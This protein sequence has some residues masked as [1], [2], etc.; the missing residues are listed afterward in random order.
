MINPLRV[1][2]SLRQ[3]DRRAKIA[4]PDGSL[5]AF[6]DFEYFHYALGDFLTISTEIACHAIDNACSGIDCFIAIDPGRPAAPAQGFINAENYTFHLEN[7]APA[8]LC[9]PM[10]RSVHFLRDRGRTAGFYRQAAKRLRRPIWPNYKS[11]I[12][13]RITY[14]LGHGAIND[15]FRRRGYV[16]Q[17]EA[18]KGYE[19]WAATYIAKNIPNRFLVAVHPRQSRLSQAPATTYRDAAL[20][21]W[22]TLFRHCASERPD[23]HFLLMGG[24]SEWHRDLY[25]LPNI[26]IPRALGLNLAH[27]LALMQRSD[28]FLGSSSGFATMATFSDIPYQ[29]SNVEHMFAPFAGIEIGENYPFAGENQNLHWQPENADTLLQFLDLVYAEG[30]D[31]HRNDGRQPAGQT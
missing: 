12:S 8:I 2:Q 16:P 29:I 14:P 18:P 28:L 7:L 15:F 1:I 31:R 3:F 20:E 21:E 11:Q 24:F 17:L 19:A 25:V 27:E 9:T 22:K 13:K 10:L 30:Q 5:A 23:I 26:T 4:L 6:I